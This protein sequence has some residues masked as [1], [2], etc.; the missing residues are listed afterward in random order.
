[1]LNGV[2]TIRTLH[3]KRYCGGRRGNGAFQGHW[4][5]S[6]MDIDWRGGFPWSLGLCARDVGEDERA[7]NKGII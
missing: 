6:D 1:M 4:P 5:S 2:E 7:A 3:N